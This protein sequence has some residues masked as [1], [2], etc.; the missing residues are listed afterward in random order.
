MMHHRGRH[1]SYASTVTVHVETLD[2]VWYDG[3]TV[4]SVRDRA[5]QGVLYARIFLDSP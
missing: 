4:E 3:A 5:Q 1:I 2:V